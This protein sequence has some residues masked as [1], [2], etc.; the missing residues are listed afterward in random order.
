M[1]E[2][3]DDHGQFDDSQPEETPVGLPWGGIVATFGLI[4][5]VM[6]AVQNT[7]SVAIEFLWMSGAYPLSIVILVTAVASAIFAS[8]GG[9]F[10]RG[11]RRR[12]REEKLELRQLRGED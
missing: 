8:L 7:E 1:D 2:I 5:V 4:L 12:R 3:H 9:V 6:F 10:Y 11:R